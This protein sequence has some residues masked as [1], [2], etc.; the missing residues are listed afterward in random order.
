M[1]NKPSFKINMPEIIGELL[2]LEKKSGIDIL[3]LYL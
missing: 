2:I 3:K 1:R